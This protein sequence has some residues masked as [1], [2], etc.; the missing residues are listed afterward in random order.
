M[1]RRDPRR[2]PRPGALVA[3]LLVAG[4]GLVAAA[5]GG[6]PSP[7]PDSTP[8]IVPSVVAPAGAVAPAQTFATTATLA[9]GLRGEPAN[10]NPLGAGGRA[11]PVLALIAAAVLPSAA[12]SGAGPAGAGQAG[13]AVVTAATETSV[14]PQTVVY[15][16]DPRAIWSD[17]VAITG[18]DFIYTWEA[19]SGEDRFRDRG[20]VDFTPGSTA[21]YRQISSVTSPADDPDQVVVRFASPDPDWRALFAPILPAHVVAAIGFDHGFTDPVTSLVSGGPFLVQSYQPGADIVLV[22]NPRWWGPTARLETLDLVFVASASEAA[23]GLQQGQLDAAVFPFPPAAV[24]ELRATPG[25]VVTE[26][27]HAQVL[28]YQSRYANLRPAPSAP[29]VSS[30]VGEW[31]VPQSA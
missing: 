10:W 22:R 26:D 16:I 21:G 4:L 8:G 31:G 2:R 5:C 25:L 14:R 29:G 6:G 23:E 27:A 17:G 12:V 9:L 19:Q 13:G 11:D 18:A 20:D 1:S 7:Q 24:T 3:G 28:V 30:N 15:E